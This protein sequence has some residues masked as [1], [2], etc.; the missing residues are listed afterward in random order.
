MISNGKSKFF[1]KNY[2]YI[3]GIDKEIILKNINDLD[4]LDSEWE[5]ECAK[6]FVRKKNLLIIP[7]KKEKN[8]A[9]MSRAGFSYDITKKIL[10]KI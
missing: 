3:K 10:D 2:L 6:I 8:F 9:K 1:I 4:L 5:L 7:E